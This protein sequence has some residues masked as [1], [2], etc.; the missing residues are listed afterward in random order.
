MAQND[1][2][3]LEQAGFTPKQVEAPESLFD[4][5]F[6]RHLEAADRHDARLAADERTKKI[7]DETVR[8]ALQ[9]IHEESVAAEV[10]LRLCEAIGAMMRDV[11]NELRFIRSEMSGIKTEVHKLLGSYAWKTAA[12]LIAQTGVIVGLIKLL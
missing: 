6:A 11:Y 10:K 5:M 12:V 9:R 4:R 7:I 2:V 3:M 1:R 8:E